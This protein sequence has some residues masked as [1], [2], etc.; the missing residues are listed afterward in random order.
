MQ[1]EKKSVLVVIPSFQAFPTFR[2]NL[3]AV[4]EADGFAVRSVV[5]AES[6]RTVI[7]NRKPHAV[8]TALDLPPDIATVETK[9]EVGGQLLTFMYN[10]PGYEPKVI[11]IDEALC[12]PADDGIEVVYTF[13]DVRRSS[14]YDVLG[15]LNQAFQA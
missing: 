1:N 12:P 15:A 9:V 14:P 5:D 3:R 13:I 7:E 8:I 4:L 2:E 11:V 10:L 6:A